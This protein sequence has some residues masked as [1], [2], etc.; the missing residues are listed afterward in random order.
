MRRTRLPG[1]YEEVHLVSLELGGPSR[2]PR[3]VSPRLLDRLSVALKRLGLN[4]EAIAVNNG[5]RDRSPAAVRDETAV[6]PELKAIDFRRNFGQ[7]AAL[8]ARIDRAMS[9]PLVRLDADL[10]NECPH[11]PTR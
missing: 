1:H 10:Q 6:Q 3:K 7:T 2:D 9:D 11:G 4:F 5:S 8:M